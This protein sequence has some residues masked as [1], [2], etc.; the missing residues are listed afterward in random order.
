MM[1]GRQG[2]GAGSGSGA[3][4]GAAG[5]AAEQLTEPSFL[6]FFSLSWYD[7]LQ[8]RT[9]QGRPPA[10]EEREKGEPLRKG[11]EKKK[12]PKLQ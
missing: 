8:R 11:K 10:M 3:G 2:S 7:A 12:D 9:A 6:F 4:A 1:C 5:R